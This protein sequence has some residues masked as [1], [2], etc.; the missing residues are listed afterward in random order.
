MST[1]IFDFLGQR[2]SAKPDRLAEPGPTPDELRQILK[3]GARVPDHKKLAPWR[4]IVFRDEARRTMGEVFAKACETEE[5]EPPSPV[6]LDMERARFMRAPVVVA[7]VSSIRNRPGVPEWEQ[8]LSAGAVCFNTCLA[9]NALGFGTSWISEWIA[10]SPSVRAA[11]GLSEKER[12]AGFIYMGQPM[13]KP[14]DRERP[15]MDKLVTEWPA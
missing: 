7:V 1:P 5:R 15:D 9:A 14:D 8:I 2:R 4:F 11:L 13:D 12:I 6:R 3:T 10:Y